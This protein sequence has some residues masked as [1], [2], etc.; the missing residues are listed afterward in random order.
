MVKNH[1]VK[2]GSGRWALLRL[3]LRGSLPLFACSMLCA[4]LVSFLDMLGPRV[5]SFTVDSVI[6]NKAPALP[7]PLMRWAEGGGVVYLRSNPWAMALAVTV[8]ALAAAIFRFLFRYLNT[9][10]AERMVQTMRDKLYRKIICLPYA[11]HGSNSTGDIIQRC[12]SDVETVKVFVSEQLTSLVRVVVLIVLAMVF[13][14][15]I[16]PLMTAAA[17]VYIPVII[18]YS[19]FF[20][21]RIG[22][23]FEKADTQEGAL[24]AIAQENL[25][26][27]RVVRAF[28]REE[29]ERS[30]F[31]K[32]NAYYTGFWIRLMKI[33]TINWVVGDAATGLQYMLVILLGTVFCINGRIT[34]GQF[35][36][37]FSYNMM[38]TWPVRSLGRVI[39][40]MSKAG[41]ALDRLHYI[42]REQTEWENAQP[43]QEGMRKEREKTGR[44]RENAQPEQE[45]M[46]KELSAKTDGLV[47]GNISFSHVSFTYPGSTG[48]ALQDISFTVKAGQTLGILGGTGSGKTTILLLLERLYTLKDGEGEITIGGRNIRQI[49]LHKL[50]RSIAMVSQEPFL[51]SRPLKDNLLIAA[52][53]ASEEELVRA[54]KTADLYQ[55][56]ENFPAGYETAVGERGVTLSGGQKQRVAIARA[57]V[58][59]CPIMVFD[60]ALSAVD[61]QTDARIRAALERETSGATVLMVSHRVSTLRGADKIIVLDQG[62]IAE[63]GTHDQLVRRNGI[64]AEIFRLQSGD[65][66]R[67]RTEE[68]SQNRTE[69]EPWSRKEEEPQSGTE[70]VCRKRDMLRSGTEEKF[71][72]G[73]EGVCGR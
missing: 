4:A 70:G 63:E 26:G 3:F 60:D 73:T 7:A 33:L 45:G 46:C 13:M 65:E 10:A 51:F 21:S 53:G 72:S 19:M 28:G 2:R 71:Q 18:A 68:K 49:P 34:A 1:K 48:F 32:Q 47:R 55:T 23:A 67:I 6:G 35:I 5:I 15:M 20:Y 24:S 56:I 11:W 25:T 16:D 31:E 69:E 36:A 42:F 64:Y 54:V 17:S 8:I 61:S 12:T 59:G 62:R 58:R 39:S 66:P 41:I 50:R 44:E 43:E 30:R 27:V 40:E 38:L 29:Y 22:N 52:E 14:V 9:A 57:L 37:F